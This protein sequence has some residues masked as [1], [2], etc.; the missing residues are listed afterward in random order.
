[1]TNAIRD[2]NFVTVALGV[3]STD[4]TVTLPFKIDSATGRLLTNSASGSG[5]VVGPASSTDN[6]VVRFNG[7]TGVLIQDSSVLIADTTG[8]ISGSEGLTLSGTTSGTTAIVATAVAGT[9]TFT[10][11]A[12]TGTAALNPMTTGGDIIYGGASGVETRL[13]NGSAN[14]VLTSNGTTLAPTWETNGAG[15]VSKVGTPVDSQVGVWTVIRH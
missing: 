11:P 2:E 12:V 4:S 6:A 9:T 1:M 5:D 13:A 14:Q 3:S 8:V 7:A 15:D 10:L